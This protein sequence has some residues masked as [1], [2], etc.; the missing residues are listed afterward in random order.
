MGAQV[1][2]GGFFVGSAPQRLRFPREGRT[3][4]PMSA[5]EQNSNRD[6]LFGSAEWYDRSI[7]WSA[8]FNRELPVLTEVL[9]PPGAGRLLDAGCGTG[10]HAC[11]LTKRGYRVVGADISET[12][13][14]L[15]RQIARGITP[16]VEFVLTPY[17]TLYEKV[18][19][20]FDGVYCLANALAAAGTGADVE[21]AVIQFGRCLR[22]GGRLFF[23]VR[24]FTAMR[25][26]DPCV[27]GPRIATVD[28]QEYVSFRWFRFGDE[29]VDVLNV[30]MWQDNGWQKHARRGRLYPAELPELQSFCDKAGLR[31][32]HT[33]GSYARE[34]FDQERSED[35]VVLATRG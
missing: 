32:E 25:L 29:V 3:N 7:N 28:G 33:W 4:M 10:R 18:G 31:I 12:M 26:Q 27:S 35:L 14:D 9:G 1:P 21:E 24:N 6:D 19:G 8:R 30:T 34:P 2:L 23:Q 5:A 15:A 13:L 17:A 22:P 16:P 20:G 11:V